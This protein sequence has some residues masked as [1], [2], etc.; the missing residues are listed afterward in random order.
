MKN[1]LSIAALLYVVH[2]GPVEVIHNLVT[3]A[4]MAG[5]LPVQLVSQ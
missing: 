1:V 3:L 2:A 4:S 5:V